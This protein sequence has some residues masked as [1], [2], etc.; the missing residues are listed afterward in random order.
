M[1]ENPKNMKKNPLILLVIIAIILTP[2]VYRHISNTSSSDIPIHGL[3][4]I[5]DNYGIDGTISSINSRL[6]NDILDDI[7]TH[8]GED[9]QPKQEKNINVRIL[10]I[11]DPGLIDS[12]GRNR[13]PIEFTISLGSSAESANNLDIVERHLANAINDGFY[14]E[15]DIKESTWD[16]T[17]ILKYAVSIFNVWGSS[18]YENYRI[19]ILSN[20][21]PSGRLPIAYGDVV[22]GISNR[23]FGDSFVIEEE[24][25]PELYLEP[26][27]PF[28][29]LLFSFYEQCYTIIDTTLFT[30]LT[31]YINDIEKYL[32]HNPEA[33]LYVI[34]SEVQIHKDRGQGDDKIAFKRAYEI[35][36]ILIGLNIPAN[37]IEL[38]DAGTTTFSWRP[39]NKFL[40]SGYF[41]PNGAELRRVAVIIP[42]T[43]QRYKE[44]LEIAK[45]LQLQ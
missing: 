5:F 9:S 7:E 40:E 39:K 36:N 17:K 26:V 33:K 23:I 19:I 44:D 25:L 3:I 42:S 2:L 18:S 41:D 20:S 10:N 12:E 43:T 35:Q 13:Q 21:L 31:N 11:R 37:R 30:Y 14:F 27:F 6:V 29:K 24:T 4:I 45:N 22:G 32:N 28:E 15:G 8:F 1:S 34:G 38:I 16:R